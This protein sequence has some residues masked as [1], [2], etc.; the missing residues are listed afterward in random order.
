MLTF[1]SGRERD[2]FENINLVV[3]LKL[4]SKDENFFFS[5]VKD[6]RVLG[7]L[8]EIDGNRPHLSLV[9]KKVRNGPYA[10]YK[11]KSPIFRIFHASFAR[12]PRF[13]ARTSDTFSTTMTSE[14]SAYVIKP[15]RMP[16][17]AEM[18]DIR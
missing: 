12:P 14:N 15:I 17:A 13:S 2:E 16:Q 10:Q 6:D 9:G 5:I 4:G 11:Q 18:A 7:W 3:G 1:G 8:G